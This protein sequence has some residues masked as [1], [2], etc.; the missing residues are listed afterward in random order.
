MTSELSQDVHVIQDAL[1]VV[2]VAAVAQPDALPVASGKMFRRTLA[3]C[4][5]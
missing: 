2:A 4:S 3:V 1:C 5:A